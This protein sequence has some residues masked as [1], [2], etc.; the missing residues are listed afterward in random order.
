M[1]E[2][3]LASTPDLE[4]LAA[5]ACEA[6]PKLLLVADWAQQGAVGPAMLAEDRGNAPELVEPRRCEGA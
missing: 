1:A 4:R 6:A 5:E 2:A 3:G